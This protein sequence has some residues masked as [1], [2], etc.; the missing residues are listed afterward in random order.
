MTCPVLCPWYHDNVGLVNFGPLLFSTIV[1]TGKY[2]ACP[3]RQICFVC[4]LVPC[5]VL[6]YMNCFIHV[7]H[8]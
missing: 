5:V 8:V 2:R 6:E 7:L 3:D 1:G 4:V